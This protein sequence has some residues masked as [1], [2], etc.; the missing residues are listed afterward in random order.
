M[1]AHPGHGRNAARAAGA[2]GFVLVGV[3]MFVL[4]LT[5]LGLSLYAISGYEGQFLTD[6]QAEEQ[7]LFRAEG[8]MALAQ[9]LLEVQPYRLDQTHFAEGY[10]GIVRATAIQER[11]AGVYDSVNVLDWSKNVVLRVSTRV[12]NQTKVVQQEFAPQQRYS[13]YRRLFTARLIEYTSRDGSNRSRANSTHLNGPR[14]AVWQYIRNASD[15]SWVRDVYWDSGRPMLT[16]ETPSPDLANYFAS[17]SAAAVT[18][19]Y[20]TTSGEHKLIMDAGSDA[21]TAYFRS[22]TKTRSAMMTAAGHCYDFYCTSELEVH[23]RGTCVWMVPAGVRFDNRVT[24]KRASGANTNPTL[25]IVTGPNGVDMNYGDYRDVALWFFDQGVR[26]DNNVR[27]IIVSTGHVRLEVAEQAGGGGGGGAA[28]PGGMDPPG[29]GGGSY[30]FT[31]PF[32]N[33]FA[34]HITMMGPRQQ[35]GDMNLSYSSTMDALV[36]DLVARGV[37]PV[38]TGQSAGGFTPVADSWRTP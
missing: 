38:A 22:P 27:V 8:G 24:F 35:D 19:P 6:T 1:R 15:T 36:D 23:V 31:L 34:D 12:G 18:A 4:A 13:P 17:N 28:R 7:A 21:A 29:G 32:L 5:I 33:I 9:T 37:L 20:D 3:V 14:Q 16:V 2:Q 11:T 30:E 25:V 10:E 26:V